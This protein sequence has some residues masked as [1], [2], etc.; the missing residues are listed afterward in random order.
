M[1]VRVPFARAGLF[2]IVKRK[3]CVGG[4]VPNRHTGVHAGS[5]ARSL[6]GFGRTGGGESQT[7]RNVCRNPIGPAGNCWADLST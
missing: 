5:L 3:R 6:G 4:G 7:C 2:V 1:A